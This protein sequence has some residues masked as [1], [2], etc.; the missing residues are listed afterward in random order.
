MVA[1]NLVLT[2]EEAGILLGISRPHAYKLVREGQIPIIRLGRRIVVPR[3]ALMR[4]LES[5]K[6]KVVLS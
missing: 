3:P 5:A 2:V 6:P 1:E 4:W